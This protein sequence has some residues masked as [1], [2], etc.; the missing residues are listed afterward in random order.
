[1]IRAPDKTVSPPIDIVDWEPGFAADFARLNLDWLERLLSVEAEDREVLGDP[2]THFLASGGHVLF[3]REAGRVV[4]TVALKNHGEGVYELAKMAVDRKAQ[5]RGI[6]WRLLGAAIDRYRRSGGTTL[7]LDTHSSLR[8]AIRL[9][10]RAG[11]RRLEGRTE[12]CGARCNLR[13]VLEESA[14]G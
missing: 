6:G 11:F 13:M 5:G 12:S 8:P 4:G 9:Y 7:Y 10:E 1:M 14:G 3:A 2:E